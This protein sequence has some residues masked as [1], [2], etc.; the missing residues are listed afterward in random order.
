M[1]GLIRRNLIY[2]LICPYKTIVLPY[3]EYYLQACRRY[4]KKDTGKLDIIHTIAVDD[5]I[6]RPHE[7]IVMPYLKS[8][9][10]LR[11]HIL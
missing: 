3:I 8:T 10:K 6:I 7:A 1:L 2:Q 11:Y 4:C 9:R 5:I